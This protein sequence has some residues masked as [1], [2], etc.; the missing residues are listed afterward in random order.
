MRGFRAKGVVDKEAFVE[1]KAGEHAAFYLPEGEAKPVEVPPAGAPD[2]S[3]LLHRVW[4]E[5]EEAAVGDHV[6]KGAQSKVHKPCAG[7]GVVLSRES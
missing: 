5:K 6:A 2:G 3:R 4:V 7:C 1:A